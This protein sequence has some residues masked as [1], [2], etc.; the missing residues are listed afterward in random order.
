M[1]R[2]LRESVV[3]HQPVEYRLDDGGRFVI[4]NYN[5]AKRFSNFLPGIGGEWG[6]PMWLYYVNR[7]QCV[8][9]FGTG[10]RDGAILEFHSF[11]NALQLTSHMGFRTFI[12][13]GG[14]TIHEPFQKSND[15]TVS[16]TMVVSSEELEISE[17]NHK[18]G[19]ETRV[20]YFP[21]V[22]EP[23]SA[24]VRELRVR[25]LRTRALTVEVLDGL[26]RVLPHGMNQQLVKFIPWHI[27]GMMTVDQVDGIPV[28]RLKQTP[29]DI[30]QVRTLTGGNFFL[31]FLGGNSEILR[32][33]LIVDPD[34]IFGGTGEYDYPWPFQSK[35]VDALI[36]MP[37]ARENKAPCAFTAVSIKLPPGEE[38]VLYSLIGHTPDEE[39]LRPL[40]AKVAVDHYVDRKSRDNR[41]TIGR[42]KNQAFT[43]SSS[44][45]FDQF[46]QQT[47]LDNVI[48]GGIPWSVDTAEAKSVF[49][50]YSRK[51]GD[52][53]RD[54]NLFDLEPTYLSQGEGY[55]R[56]VN[57]NRRSDVW[58]FPEVGESNLVTF[59]GLIQTDGYNP[60]VVGRVTYTA[61][62]TDALR[63]WLGTLVR[64]PGSFRDLLQLV[65]HPFTP[66]EFISKFERATERNPG[67]YEGILRALLRFC[68]ANGPGAPR[69]GFWTD[70]WTYNLDLIDRFLEIYP[71]RLRDVLLRQKV[72]T[73]FDNPD[74]V[75]PRER[76]YVLVDGKV[77]QYGSVVRDQE[78]LEM[79]EARAQDKYAVRT[80]QGHGPVYKTNMLVKL[81]SIVANKMATLDHAGIGVMMEADKPGWCDPLNGLPGLLGFSICETLELERLC[82]FL[83]KSFDELK[84]PDDRPIE[85][86]EELYRFLTS[87][88]EAVGARL[89]STAVD[90]TLAYWQQSNALKERYWEDTRFG[91]TGA[92]RTV[93]VATIRSF[94]GRA[95]RLLGEATDRGNEGKAFDDTGVCY[96]Y[97]INEV[98]EYEAAQEGPGD[99]ALVGGNEKPRLRVRQFSSRPLSR[100]LEGPVHLLRVRP[101]TKDQIYRAVRES[102]LFDRKLNMYRCCEPLDREPVEIG[103]IRAYSDGWIE[104]GSIYLHMEYKWLL[105]LLRK[106]LHREFYRDLQTTL[107]PFLDPDTYGRSILEG[108]S[109][110]VSSG[111]PDEKLHG[112]GFQPRLSGCTCEVLHMWT[113]M[114]AGE[115]PFSLNDQGQLTLQLRPVLPG[116][117]FTREERKAGFYDP[118]GKWTS[119]VIP[120]TPSGSGSLARASW[121]TTTR[122]GETRSART[123]QRWP[124]IFSSIMMGGKGQW[125]AAPWSLR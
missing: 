19:I 82:R 51:H 55:Y 13:I 18:L 38:G 48:R 53:E 67:K 31:S 58:F 64:D 14:R 90:R 107:I 69:E 59:L 124:P 36:S 104:N 43:V 110:I 71:E 6:I 105:E 11:N 85:V 20:R 122:G 21:L 7:A 12:K 50:P 109:Y 1:T 23:I 74:V 25:N 16:Q 73:F 4:E 35:S 111:F 24:L 54:Y 65:L 116:W 113:L 34:I 103:R 29:E 121:S 37:Q 83:R 120:K 102:P 27:Q 115:N 41:S 84:L 117:L 75:V 47:F 40:L 3:D 5:W 32:R 46:C 9:S 66:G 57:Q 81:L 15:A 77:R 96:T 39:S 89:D 95:L 26:P 114:V 100:F 45:R 68:R 30:P 88:D 87:L 106:G 60:Q 98:T 22:D 97:F 76:K 63:A 33:Q 2:P 118:R 52:L 123:G 78:K 62:D 93:T 79:I 119:V 44:Q 28:F 8:S 61:E 112:R 91:I 49:Y 92:E 86:Y 108:S 17:V 99:G 42:I 125:R 10:S 101:E 94:L 80:L 70:H 72:F 56:D